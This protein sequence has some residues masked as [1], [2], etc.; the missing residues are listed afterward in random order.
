MWE[1][2]AQ[3]RCLL[4]STLWRNQGKDQNTV[5]RAAAQ[6]QGRLARRKPRA[7]FLLRISFPLLIRVLCISSSGSNQNT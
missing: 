6:S 7:F 1:L 3:L 5:A 4:S 2:C